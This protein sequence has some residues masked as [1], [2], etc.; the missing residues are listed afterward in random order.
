MPG[1]GLLTWGRMWSN[2]LVPG[3]SPQLANLLSEA[4]KFWLFVY[5][6]ALVVPQIVSYLGHQKLSTYSH[7]LWRSHLETW[8]ES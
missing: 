1:A 6:E 3:N 4:H 8:I 5:S 7:D 2:S